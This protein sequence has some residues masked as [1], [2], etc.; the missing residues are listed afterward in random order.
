MQQQRYYTDLSDAEWL[1]VKPYLPERQRRGR[2]W[3]HSRREI[4]NAL[5]RW[6][7]VERAFA[8]LGQN[9]RLSKDYERLCETSE[10]LIYAAMSRV[11]MHRLAR[12]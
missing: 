9:R 2:P 5:P 10:S 7:V 4:L 3:R 6:W 12:T 11:M 8:W 1:M